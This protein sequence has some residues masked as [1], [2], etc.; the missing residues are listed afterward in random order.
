M[1]GWCWVVDMAPQ[2]SAAV[3]PGAGAGCW[4]CMLQCSLLHCF[5]AQ[6]QHCP[7]HW[8][9]LAFTYNLSKA[10]RRESAAGGETAFMSCMP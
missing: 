2:Q 4:L 5:Q 1:R 6:A 10:A 3:C 9:S 7:A 8:P